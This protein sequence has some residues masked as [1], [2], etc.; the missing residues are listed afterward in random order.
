[1]RS[2]PSKKSTKT[3]RTKRIKYSKKSKRIFPNVPVYLQKDNDTSMETEH[4]QMI[5]EE[6]YRLL[7]NMH[8]PFGS[9]FDL[10]LYGPKILV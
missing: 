4:I 3:L 9:D 7:N 6:F 5:E 2:K 10:F 8:D 1:M